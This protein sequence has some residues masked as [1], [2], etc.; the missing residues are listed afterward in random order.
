MTR[1]VRP[2]LLVLVASTALAM[3]VAALAWACVPASYLWAESAFGPPGGTITVNGKQFEGGS[4]EIR[5]GSESGPVL[6]VAPDADFATTVEVPNPA[7]DGVYMLLALTR[8]QDGS[9][10]E[11]NRTPFEVTRSGSPS[12]WGDGGWSQR[13]PDPAVQPSPSPGGNAAPSPGGSPV[14]SPGG[15]PVSSPGVGGGQ[16]PFVQAPE[17]GGTPQPQ[18][19][20]RLDRPTAGQGPQS[21]SRSSEERVFAGSTPPAERPVF[22]G[23]PSQSS[24]PPVAERATAERATSDRRSYEAAPADPTAHGSNV[25]QRS[26]TGDTWSGFEGKRSSLNTSTPDSAGPGSQVM[27]GIGLLVLGLV[28]LA[29]GA[30]GAGLRRRRSYVSRVR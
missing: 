14:S 13:P 10:R 8:N 1:C 12:S 23:P 25:S 4:V 29:A 6:A 17:G 9:I 30:A 28:G 19:E 27:V 26:A 11:W 20:G 15:S 7:E 3:S 22:A 18:L 5:W 2:V 21:R 24:L 16:V